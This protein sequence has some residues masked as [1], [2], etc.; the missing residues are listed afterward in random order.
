MA[1][2]VD[3]NRLDPIPPRWRPSRW[4]RLKNDA[5]MLLHVRRDGELRPFMLRLSDWAG[6]FAMWR[7]AQRGHR[8]QTRDSEPLSGI[9]WCTR[10]WRA[11]IGE[12]TAFDRREQWLW[13]ERLNERLRAEGYAPFGEEE[14]VDA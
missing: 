2:L 11:S 1:I 3:V 10:C 6:T 5:W 12:P 8:W 4:W 14:E 13:R 9:R 7:C